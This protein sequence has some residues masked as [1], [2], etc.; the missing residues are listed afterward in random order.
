MAMSHALA[1]ATLTDILLGENSPHIQ[2][3]VGDPGQNGTANPARKGGDAA[4]A[5][6][7]EITFGTIKSEAGPPTER[8][9]D[10]SGEIVWTDAQIDAGQEISYFT[11]WSAETAG[12]IQFIAAVDTAKTTGSDGVT[13]AVE[14]LLVALEV[15]ALPA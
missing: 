14:D 8:Y 5:D 1:D 6:L 7:K 11:I 13:I 3:H 2:L 9:V 15:Y 10:N 12:T 4:D